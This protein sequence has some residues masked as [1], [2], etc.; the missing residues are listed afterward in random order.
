MTRFDPDQHPLPESSSDSDQ[1]PAPGDTHMRLA[2]PM[3]KPLWTFFLLG[4]IILVYLIQQALPSF[5]ESLL[6]YLPPEYDGLTAADFQGGSTNRFV[7]VLMGANVP[8]LVAQ[9]QVWRFFTSMF[10]HIGFQHLLFNGYALFIFGPEMERVY[11]R[12]RF[13]GIYILGG[14]FGSLVSFALSQ[15]FLSAGA[16]GAIFGLIGMQLAYFYRHKERLGE[17]GRS[18]LMNTLFIIGLNIV[19]GLTVPG[20]DNWAHMGGLLCGAGLGYLLAPVYE[21]SWQ[22]TGQPEVVDKSE[23]Q[24]HLLILLAAAAI[25]AAA[26][27]VLV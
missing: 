14:L 17:L 19:F 1:Q 12:F 22:Y 27:W 26:T 11:G 16:S 13:I 24:S 18:R 25:F 6:P 2:L 4:A 10:L 8:L 3:S 7:L 21:V 5:I 9:G 20:I 23:L 15:A